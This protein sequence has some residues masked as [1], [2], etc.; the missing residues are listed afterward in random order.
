[1]PAEITNYVGFVLVV[2]GREP[3]REPGYSASTVS[4]V[5]LK[6]GTSPRAIHQVG[7]F[8]SMTP[9][10]LRK[11]YNIDDDDTQ[12]AHPNKFFGVFTPVW[13]TWLADDMDRFLTDFA[14]DLIGNRPEKMVMNGATSRRSTRLPASISKPIWTTSTQWRW[15]L[16]HPS[17]TY[18][19][20]P[21]IASMIATINDAS[22]QAGRALLEL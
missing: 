5:R 1:L 9:Q 13:S 2:P 22:F 7:C 3:G 4:S 6:D 20:V 21:L 16:Q 12:Q 10:C 11:L 17:L 15:H 8:N 19:S 18:K 14:P